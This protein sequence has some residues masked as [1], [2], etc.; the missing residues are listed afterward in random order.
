MIIYK[1]TNLINGKIYIGQD[2]KNNPNYLGSG[3]ILKFALKKY[4]IENFKKEILEECLTL[5][6]LNEL[7]KYW[8]NKFNSTDDNIGY[9][10]SF[11]GQSGWM[12]GVKHSDETKLNYSL[13]RK[14]KLLGEKNGMFGKHHTEESKKKMGKPKDGE[15]NGMFGKNHTEES[16]KK[17]HDKMLGNKNPFYG[18][19]HS[20]ETKN[21][22]SD[23]AKKRISS[24]TSKKVL[25]GDDIFNSATEAAKYFN[26]SIGT[27]SYRCRNNIK[28]WTY[29][30]PVEP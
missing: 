28:N 15:K 8:I 19:K 21:K 9:N 24:P 27:A 6:E 7:E 29:L 14:G 30:E 1:T 22:L 26:I 20:E 23:I 2:T 18:K 13:N 12:L 11:G 16:K 17:L 5:D 4:G 25:V 10:L 3:K